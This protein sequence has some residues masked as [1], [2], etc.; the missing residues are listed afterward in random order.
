MFSLLAGGWQWVCTSCR[1]CPAPPRPAVPCMPLWR[2]APAHQDQPYLVCLYGGMLQLIKTS[3]TLY[4]S[5][6]ACSSLSRPPLPC[7]PL[8]RH[9]PAYRDQH[10]TLYASMEACSSSSKTSTLHCMPLCR[11]APAYQDQPYL[12]CLYGGM[13]QLFQDQHP[14]WYATIEA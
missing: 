11:H 14:T 12:V 2:H 6:E 7:V 10:P 3:P 13:I 9:A 8:W 4:V 5:I 1:E